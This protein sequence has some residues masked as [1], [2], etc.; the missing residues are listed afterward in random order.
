V[1]EQMIDI[2]TLA[3]EEIIDPDHDGASFHQAL[4]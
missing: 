2:A 1:I 3:G 4:A